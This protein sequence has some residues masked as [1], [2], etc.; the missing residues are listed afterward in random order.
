[1]FK[2][3]K[4]DCYYLYLCNFVYSRDNSSA[5]A[6]YHV[7]F[8]VCPNVKFAFQAA[9]I[10]QIHRTELNIVYYRSPL[11]LQLIYDFQIR[12]FTIYVD[13]FCSL[14]ILNSTVISTFIASA[15]SWHVKRSENL[16]HQTNMRTV[17]TNYRCIKFLNLPVVSQLQS[18]LL[19]IPGRSLNLI[20]R[21]SLVNS[22]QE[23][24]NPYLW[25]EKF[26]PRF[27][28]TRILIWKGNHYSKR[29]LLH[30]DSQ[31]CVF[32]FKKNAHLGPVISCNYTQYWS[33]CL[34]TPTPTIPLLHLSFAKLP[35]SLTSCRVN[36]FHSFTIKCNL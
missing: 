20:Y 16:L 2:I 29:L 8:Q 28:L 9:T 12:V 19:L 23:K 33:F 26:D 27:P 17:H 34:S 4:D 6:H 14:S 36:P 32:R 18:L 15:S 35:P 11:F 25:T 13:I 22:S 30:T 5:K 21:L 31:A 24:L 10:I 3:K 1:M 7:E